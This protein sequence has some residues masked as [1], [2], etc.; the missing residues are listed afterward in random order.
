MRY[1]IIYN[2]EMHIIESKIYG[3]VILSQVKELIA[4]YAAIVKEKGCTLIFSDYRQATIKL[5]TIE[6]YE[7]P[8]IYTDIFALSRLSIYRV[9]R[10]LVVAEDLKDYLFFETVTFNQ[11]QFAKIFKDFTEAREWLLSK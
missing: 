2:S 5:S 6:I 9:K 4:E 8:K 11:G 10:A 3:D 1:S 7:L